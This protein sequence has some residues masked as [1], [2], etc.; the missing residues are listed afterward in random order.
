MNYLLWYDESTQKSATDKIHE[1]MGAYV[2]RFA[3]A[4][5]VVLVSAK[6]HL[7]IPGVQIR[8]ERTVQ[9]NNF[10]VGLQEDA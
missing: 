5:N 10:W 7:E 2:A 8:V 6:D 9:P 1:A 4:P 3:V